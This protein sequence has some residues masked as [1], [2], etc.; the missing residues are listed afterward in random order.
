MIDWRAMA[1]TTDSHV[2]MLAI[3]NWGSAESGY[4]IPDHGLGKFEYADLCKLAHRSRDVYGKGRCVNT[5]LKLKLS[6]NEEPELWINGS[7]FMTVG[8][9]NIATVHMDTKDVWTHGSAT[10]VS[11]LNSWIP[12]I[13]E[14]HRTGIYRMAHKL[15][16]Y[17]QL[18]GYEG[19]D[20]Y[21]W[22]AISKLVKQS[23]VITIGLRYNL[24][25]GE[26]LNP[27]KANEPEKCVE[28]ADK[29]KVWRKKIT[30]FKK[31][32]RVRGKLGLIESTIDELKNI[33]GGKLLSIVET[34]AKLLG[35]YDEKLK[36]T[37]YRVRPV[38]KPPTSGMYQH[39]HVNWDTP[40]SIEFLAKHIDTNAMPSEIYIP[41]CIALSSI[42]S[43]TDTHYYKPKEDWS[44]EINKFFGKLS[45]H[46]RRHYGVIEKEAT[47][48]SDDSL[49]N[50]NF[51]SYRYNNIPIDIKQIHKTFKGVLDDNKN[52]K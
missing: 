30:A 29:R 15:S 13:V 7:K 36:E 3:D 21:V 32:L 17:K 38:G 35:T 47:V 39:V 4:K 24:L 27:S 8:K 14:R 12:F 16:L 31:Q 41:I 9:D 42:R 45:I 50:F 33:D 19:D 48:E 49:Y 22:Y 10:F 6:S 1:M 11:A 26:L 5:W 25:T 43:H 46:L 18:E 2:K 34:H 40:E 37:L 52:I 28:N 23:Q 20:T 44:S 51:S